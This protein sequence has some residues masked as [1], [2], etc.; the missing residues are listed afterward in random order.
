MR[1]YLLVIGGLMLLAVSH[2][3]AEPIRYGV[4][5]SAGFNIPVLQDDQSKGTTFEFR[6]RFAPAPFLTVE[7]KLSLT[8]YGSPDSFGDIG[9]WDID[10]S[11]ITAYGVDG[12]LGSAMGGPGFWPFF[13]AGIGFHSV[14]NSDTEA[15]IESQTKFG[16]NAG[17]GAAIGV[18]PQLAIDVRGRAH[19]ISWGGTAKKSLSIIGGLNYHFGATE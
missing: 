19:F 16:W 18:S 10:G 12:V 1:K 4:G 5:A 6:A 2:L 7:P 17:L 11:K 13:T 15:F 8:S 9:T 14:S 3:A